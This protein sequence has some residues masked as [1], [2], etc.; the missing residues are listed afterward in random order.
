MFSSTS[1]YSP[2]LQVSSDSSS[3]SSK[4]PVSWVAMLGDSTEVVT[5]CAGGN[6]GCVATVGVGTTTV[7]GIGVGVGTVTETCDGG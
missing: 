7:A 6:G 2:V 3:K 1:M 5:P 4:Y